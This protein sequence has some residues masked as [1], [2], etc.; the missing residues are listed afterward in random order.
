[1]TFDE[2]IRDFGGQIGVEL[3]PRDGMVALDIDGMSVL[4]QE[5]RELDAVVVLGEIGEPPP[6][7]LETLLST[8]LNANHL[9]AGTG[10]GTL[11][12][13]PES[14]KFYLCRW[15]PLALADTAS[16]TAMM[17]RFVNVLET[18]RKL[19]AD[20]RPDEAVASSGSDL[21]VPALG[22]NGFLK[23]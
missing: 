21:D 19:V 11:S 9:F 6:E 10:G 15:Q 2:L 14:G 16:F 20:Y 22:G 7:G 5:L 12:R 1:M 17:D 13:D 18:W 3:T 8:M 4:I 23:I